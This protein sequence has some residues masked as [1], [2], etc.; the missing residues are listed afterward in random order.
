MSSDLVRIGFIGA[1]AICRLKHLPGLAPI[2]DAEVVAVCNR[3]HASSQA[4]ASEFGIAGEACHGPGHEH[5]QA[6]RDPIQ[7]YA[8]HLSDKSDATI[9]NPKGL[10]HEVSS[11]VCGQ[12]HGVNLTLHKE[13]ARRWEEKGF[14]FRPGDDMGKSSMRFV[15]L[16]RKAEPFS[17][18]ERTDHLKRVSC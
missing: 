8:N 1:G 14:D 2:D 11:Q 9:V 7:R 17:L 4:I 15:G 18:V 12:C 6:N 10:L 13:A 16:G 3:S 5:V